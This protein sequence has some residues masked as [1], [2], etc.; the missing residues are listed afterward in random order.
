MGKRRHIGH[1]LDPFVDVEPYRFR[2]EA[3]LDRAMGQGIVMEIAFGIPLHAHRGG[4][5]E[6]F[7]ILTGH[8]W[9]GMA[10]A[11]VRQRPCEAGAGDIKRE[12]ARLAGIL[13]APAGAIHHPEEGRF[14]PGH[15]RHA[16]RGRDEGAP[17]KRRVGDLIAIGLID[18]DGVVVMDGA[19][20]A[21]G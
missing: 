19:D 4:V 5:L 6:R 10:G 9:L 20:F 14:Y 18:S 13:V 12:D 11:A 1:A 2:A 15:P 7:P 21:L 3:D 17:G 16:E 8:A